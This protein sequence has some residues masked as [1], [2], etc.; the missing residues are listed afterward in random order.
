MDKRGP[1]RSCIGCR[2]VF[3]KG[4]LVRVVA[5]P[6]GRLV[7]DYNAKLPGRGCYV[8]PDRRCI[9][10]A[11]K[12][13]AFGRALRGSVRAVSSDD[14][15]GTVLAMAKNRMVGYLSLARR[16]GRLLSGM[17]AVEEG[18]KKGK[19]HLLLV[20]SDSSHDSRRKLERRAAERGVHC[21]I[22]PFDEKFDETT[23]GRKLL[24]ITDPGL[25]GALVRELERIGRLEPGPRGDAVPS[26][27]RR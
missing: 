1:R 14:L 27:K 11:V 21:A 13:K 9:E 4:D 10:R 8:C 6:D 16:S 19:V 7:V 17:K 24:G 18:L 2:E 22:L 25:G 3:G 20:R 5:S 23:G 12:A 15:V 26:D